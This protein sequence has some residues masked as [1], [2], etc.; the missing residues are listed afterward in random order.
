MPKPSY[1]FVDNI[2]C[3]AILGIVIEHCS[4]PAYV[5]AKG[6]PSYWPFVITAQ[7]FKFGTIAF[8]L[9]A[10]F[11]FAEH[12]DNY[13]PFDY[14][15][16]RFNNIFRPWLIWSLTF[17]LF[18]CGASI[19]RSLID[20]VPL[21]LILA[22]LWWG[23]KTV[24]LHSNYWFI[25]NF[26]FCTTVLL[27]S[28]RILH[29]WKFG[30]T[31]FF[32]TSFYGINVYTEWII[33]HHTTAIFGFILFYWLGIQLN[34]HINQVQNLIDRTPSFVILFITSLTLFIAVQ[35]F[36]YLHSMGKTDPNNTLKFSNMFFSITIFL[37]FL[38]IKNF[39]WLSFL[40]PRKTTYGIF[41]IHYIIVAAI[42]PLVFGK[43]DSQT[44]KSFSVIEMFQYEVSRFLVVYL[45]SYGL[46]Q[47]IGRSQFSWL[48]GG[49]NQSKKPV[50]Q[51]QQ[52][53]VE[54]KILKTEAA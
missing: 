18:L 16:R 49:H 53:A 12:K 45:L 32:L 3:I 2:R 27:L 5:F 30:L 19:V 24:Y 36:S 40:Q 51:A 28:K 33:P 23:I 31:L 4:I 9:I 6:D 34:Y 39:N 8:F 50:Q 26:L 46:V 44:I 35:E 41:L 37:A 25:M 47:L 42:L 13:S 21:K 1:Q 52:E 10:G 29:S 17:L 38:K 43:E 7:A 11:L 20:G 22:G 15:K 14:L 48:I 54:L